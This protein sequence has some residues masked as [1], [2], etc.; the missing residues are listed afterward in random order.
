MKYSEATAVS[1]PTWQGALIFRQVEDFMKRASLGVVGPSAF[2][3]T[4]NPAWHSS[5]LT[6]TCYRRLDLL[7]GTSKMIDLG[8]GRVNKGPEP[9]GS[10]VPMKDQ[11]YPLTPHH[12][13]NRIDHRSALEGPQK[14]HPCGESLSIMI[15]PVNAIEPSS[16]VDL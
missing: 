2:L 9:Q 15:K 7:W 12:I 3:L 8:A 10:C 6:A 4:A 5:R 14:Q 11:C 13:K 1:L 16:S